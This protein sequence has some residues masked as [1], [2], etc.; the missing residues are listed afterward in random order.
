LERDAAGLAGRSVGELTKAE[1][2]PR[3]KNGEMLVRL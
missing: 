3:R 2:E 1:K